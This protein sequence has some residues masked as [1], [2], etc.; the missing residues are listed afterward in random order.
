MGH[1]DKVV[2]E[3]FGEGKTDVRSGPELQRPQQG[4]V[5]IL[6]HR[7]CGRPKAMR[8]KCYT[9]IYLEKVD[10]NAGGGYEQ[11]ATAFRKL[12]CATNRMQW[13]S[14]WIQTVT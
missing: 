4:V 10:V 7:L 2:V 1:D 12:A 14:S 9:R 5:P 11:K 13:S 3:V 8:V 6:L